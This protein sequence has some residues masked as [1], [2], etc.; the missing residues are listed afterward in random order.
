MTT[1]I[2]GSLNGTALAEGK[3]GSP[4]QLI[5][6]G[7]TGSSEQFHIG[8]KEVQGTSYVLAVPEGQPG[9]AG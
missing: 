7:N 4:L 6:V 2:P 5:E 8:S 3:G 9:S 1:L